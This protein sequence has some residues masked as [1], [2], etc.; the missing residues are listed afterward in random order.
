MLNYLMDW[1]IK[2]ANAEKLID[3]YMKKINI[4]IKR[5]TKEVLAEKIK[6]TLIDNIFA[7]FYDKYDIGNKG[8]LIDS[9]SIQVIPDDKLTTFTIYVFFNNSKLMHTTWYGSKSLGIKDGSKVYTAEWINDGWTYVPVDKREY[10]GQRLRDIGGVEFIEETI[11]ALEFKKDW[12]LSFY[13]YL[14]FNG[15][16]IT[17]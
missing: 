16:E 8:W 4:V 12:I 15:I 2:M 6:E 11:S 9:L 5:G 7:K 17:R 3:A 13:Q 14:K 10:V 1:V